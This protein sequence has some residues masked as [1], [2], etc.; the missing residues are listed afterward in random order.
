M[1]HDFAKLRFLTCKLRFL[2]SSSHRTVG[3]LVSGGAARDDGLVPPT[4]HG[5]SA[6]HASDSYREW[7]LV[8]SS[9]ASDPF[10]VRGL[11]DG[12]D[13]HVHCAVSVFV[14]DPADN[15]DGH[16]CDRDRNHFSLR[17]ICVLELASRTAQ[18]GAGFGFP[19]AA[20]IISFFLCSEFI[21]ACFRTRFFA[22]RADQEVATSMVGDIMRLLPPII[23]L[24]ISLMQEA[25]N[26][27][28]NSFGRRASFRP[29][30]ARKT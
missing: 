20:G 18:F 15:H 23:C 3:L 10:L 6:A 24:T 22:G 5:A 9:S 2:T 11:R 1:C 19:L 4:R 17:R 25:A 7:L 30:A 14:S 8:R 27:P 21:C 26:Y 12:A 29:S 13:R 28:T 16:V